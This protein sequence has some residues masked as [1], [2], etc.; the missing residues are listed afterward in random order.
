MV[1]DVYDETL[2]AAKSRF[3][4]AFP[5][6]S[7]PRPGGA[8]RTNDAIPPATQGFFLSPHIDGDTDNFNNVDDDEVQRF[9]RNE[10]VE[11]DVTTIFY[12]SEDDGDDDSG[13]EVLEENDDHRPKNLSMFEA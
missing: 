12:S 9:D 4:N 3:V 13:D 8:S 7:P 6:T 5:P 2:Q 10:L 1:L 11:N